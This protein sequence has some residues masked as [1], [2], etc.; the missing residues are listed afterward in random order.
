M[1]PNL[2]RPLTDSEVS[3]AFSNAHEEQDDAGMGVAVWVY[4]M[5]DGFPMINSYHRSDDLP[6]CVWEDGK[7][8]WF[9]NGKHHRDFNRPAVIHADGSMEWW[10]NNEMTGDQDAPPPNAVFPG[11]Q[12][13][14]ASK[15]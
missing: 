15:K 2:M 3:E 11:Q 5:N 4:D 7:L 12:T 13:K 8:A 14:S 9:V 6:A 1:E 10:V